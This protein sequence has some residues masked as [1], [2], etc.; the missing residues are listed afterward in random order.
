MS[1]V[2][3]ETFPVARKDY[4]CGACEWLN[5]GGLPD[6]T[7]SEAKL[8][9]KARR[10]GFKIKTGQKY[11]KQAN[12]FSGDFCCFRARPEMHELCLKYDIYEEP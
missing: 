7:F 1:T 2:L 9:I 10:D 11:V 5:E 6:M 4:P 8:Y 3:S 12:I